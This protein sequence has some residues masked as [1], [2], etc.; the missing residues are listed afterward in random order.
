MAKTLLL[1][2]PLTL[3]QRMGGLAEAGAVMPALGVLYI[4]SWM[5]KQLLEVEIL[6][7]ESLRL[8]L[9]NTVKAILD[10]SPDVLGITTTTLSIIPAAEIAR[11]I[12]A[13]RKDIKIF[14]GGP[15]V[16]ALPHESLQDFADIDGCIL[17]D[18]EI[19]FAH[20]VRNISN[21]LNAGQGVDGIMW[22]EGVEISYNP[23]TKHLS[24]LDSL[25]FPAW[26]LLKGFP[27]NYRPAFHSYRRLPQ[28]NIILTRGCPYACSF[29]DRSVFG[30]KIY[31]HSVDYAI[32]MIEYLVKDFGIKEI[33]IKD[34]TFLLSP[35]R[36]AE[37]CQR[38]R[39]K[40]IDL[41]WSC[42]GRVN[43]ITEDILREMKSAGCWLISY[44]IESGSPKMLKKM[45]KDINLGQVREALRLTRSSG[46]VAK[47]FFMIG[48]PGETEESLRQTLD[49]V[50]ELP[51]DELNVNFFTPF[52]GSRLYAEVIAEGFKPEFCRMNMTEP[53]YVPKG[54]TAQNL[55]EYQK[56]IIYSFYLRPSKVISYA[57][58]ALKDVH[59]FKRIFRMTNIFTGFM[60]SG[61]KQ[62]KLN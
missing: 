42:N 48:I 17:G 51:L 2:P 22:R 58:R 32:E 47:G 56:R 20:I 52:P 27:K 50:N 57:S 5:R 26:D 46:I 15:H 9:D 61:F 18:G 10:R 36:V 24:D 6:D 25:P 11:E 62:R 38:I 49:F 54:L 59:E 3:S 21:G 4:A 30:N 14:L 45:A 16:T 23:K 40:R 7:A 55:C 19:S 37:F 31:S 41:T 13:R 8:D 53:S 33:S 43:T 39:Q 28:A 29:C 12:K 60:F 35:E 34:D 44:G 1:I